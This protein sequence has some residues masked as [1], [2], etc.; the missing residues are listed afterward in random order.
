[1]E[2]DAALGEWLKWKDGKYTCYQVQ[3][4]IIK[5]MASEDLQE[6]SSN[7]HKSPF[8]TVMNDET[9][10]VSKCE[11]ATIV[12]RQ[13]TDEMEMFEEFLGIYQVPSIDS[14]TLSKVVKDVLCRHNLSLGKLRGQCYDEASG[15]QGARS[16]VATKIYEEERRA[17]Y[18]HLYGHSITLAASD[19]IK[20]TKVMKHAMET[21]HEITKLVKYLPSW[22]QIFHNHKVAKND[23]HG[24]GLRVLCPKRWM[25]KA[26]IYHPLS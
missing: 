6:V 17:L 4:E 7:L 21:A 5:I 1:M 11:Q 26:T 19:A 22:E 13:V 14:S 12:L 3:N 24:P 25:M 16:G 9:T 10:D 2:D 15:M 23:H 20:R 18:T 8:L